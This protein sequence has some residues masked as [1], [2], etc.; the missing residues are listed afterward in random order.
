MEST[1]SGV[2]R[3]LYLFHLASM[4][5]SKNNTFSVSSQTWLFIFLSRKTWNICVPT[6][7]SRNGL[8]ICFIN[9]TY[10]PQALGQRNHF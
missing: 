4:L 7:E 8:F 6:K 1:V 9:I 3:H 5:S 10:H 2:E